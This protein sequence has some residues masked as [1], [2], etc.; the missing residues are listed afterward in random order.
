MVYIKFVGPIYTTDTVLDVLLT[1]SRLSFLVY[2]SL[3]ALSQRET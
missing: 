2:A 1:D 3:R